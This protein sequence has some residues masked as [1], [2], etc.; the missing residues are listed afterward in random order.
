MAGAHMRDLF[1]ADPERFAR[2]SVRWEDLI[3]D[4]SKHRITPE[5]MSLLFALARESEVTSWRDRMFAGEKINVTEGRAVL[6]TALRNMSGRPVMVDGNDVM[7]GVRSVLAHMRTF[8]DA[9][10]S[11]TWGGCTGKKICDVVNIGIGGSDLGPVMVTEALKHYADSGIRSY[12]VS[13]VD[14][15]HIA[16]TLKMLAP[17]RRSSSSHRRHSRRRRR[18]RTLRRPASGS[19]GTSG[20]KPRSRSIL[21]PFPRTKKR[22]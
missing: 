20:M 12:F 22:R 19:S 13:N 6:H 8:S 7:P 10:R 2:F 1:A 18:S 3:V 21:S 11:G 5:T 15:T 14:G 4:Y 9:V 17:E 16:E